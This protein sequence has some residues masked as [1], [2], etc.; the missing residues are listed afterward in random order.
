MMLLNKQQQNYKIL[1]I[2]IMY[3]K[4]KASYESA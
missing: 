4:A 1:K 2:K 3:I